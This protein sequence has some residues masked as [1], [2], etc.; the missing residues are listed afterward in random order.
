M[1][2]FATELARSKADNPLWL[3]RPTDQPTNRPTDQP[4][5]RPTDQ[6]TNRPTDQPTN[7]PTDQ[8]TNRPT[9]QPTNRPTDQPTNRPTGFQEAIDKNK[10][11]GGCQA[12]QDGPGGYDEVTVVDRTNRPAQ[13]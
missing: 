4:T 12:G 8:P 11:S 10:R 5:Y 7:R 2:V 13:A 3:Y 1:Q 6:P 9:D